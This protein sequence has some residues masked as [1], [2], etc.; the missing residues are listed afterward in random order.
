[1]LHDY[2][3]GCALARSLGIAAQIKKMGGPLLVFAGL[4][5]HINTIIFWLPLENY[6]IVSWNKK[7]LKTRRLAHFLLDFIL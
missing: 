6:K 7:S 2:F 3:N 4:W 5:F 1:M